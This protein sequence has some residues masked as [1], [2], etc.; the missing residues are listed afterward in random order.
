MI[1]SFLVPN[2]ILS[3]AVMMKINIYKK[4]FRQLKRD[5]V[6]P[7]KKGFIVCTES[8]TLIKRTTKFSEV[9]IRF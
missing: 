5:Y 7:I 1:L 3:F 4:I 2:N 6:F 9:K 8:H